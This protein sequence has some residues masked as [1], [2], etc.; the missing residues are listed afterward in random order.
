MDFGLFLYF[1]NL[2]KGNESK[3]FVLKGDIMLK[4]NSK[5]ID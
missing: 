5:V 2:F 1:Y 3:R 4:L